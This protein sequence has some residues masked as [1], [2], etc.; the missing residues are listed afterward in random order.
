MSIT[1][2]ELRL[3]LTA[4]GLPAA[5]WQL[6]D[7]NYEFATGNFVMENWIAWMDSRPD[8]LK[9]FYD[10]GGGKTALG[11]QLKIQHNG[12]LVEGR[13]SWR[14]SY[15]AALCDI[16]TAA[17]VREIDTLKRAGEHALETAL[18]LK[19]NANRRVLIIDEGE[20]FGPRTINLVKLILNQSPTVVVILAIPQLYDWWQRAAWEQAKQINR[21][22]EA[23]VVCLT[24]LPEDVQAFL[25]GTGIVIEAGQNQKPGQAL[26]EACKLIAAAANEFGAFDTVSRIIE[27]IEND[28]E[29]VAKRADIEKAIVSVKKLLNRRN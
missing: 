17:E 2:Q 29:G 23:V 27:V 5:L 9:T 15:L 14:R 3:I 16:A 28:F 10:V 20:Y 4:A 24:V 13:E 8:E 12:I 7:A 22:A 25:G 21:R 19:F 18:I 1:Q 26:Q 6:P 11:R